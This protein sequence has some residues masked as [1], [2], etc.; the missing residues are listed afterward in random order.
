M[1]AIEMI[2]SSTGRS[3]PRVEVKNLLGD[4]GELAIK[5][6]RSTISS[7]KTQNIK[8]GEK[9]DMGVKSKMV[10]ARR[11]KYSFQ[12]KLF[13]KDQALKFIDDTIESIT[14]GSLSEWKVHCP[15]ILRAVRDRVAMITEV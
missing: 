5:N 6:E 3:V 10:R 1:T 2:K 15:G 7:G 11:S 13:T 14:E 12:E 4:G 9:A 8:S